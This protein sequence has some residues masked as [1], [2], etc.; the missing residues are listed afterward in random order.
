MPLAF[1][2]NNADFSNMADL[3]A[4]GERLY[5]DFVL[6]KAFVQVDENGTEAAAATAVGVAGGGIMGYAPPPVLFTAD[7][8]FQFYIRDNQTGTILFM[9]RV[10]D[11]TQQENDVTPIAQTVAAAS[12]PAIG[13]VVI[14]HAQLGAQTRG[15]IT[16]NVADAT[17]VQSSSI[18][19]DGNPVK[20]VYGP[21]GS[22][23]GGNY[24]ALCGTL[25]AGTNTC[26]I[27]A[28]AKNG[29]TSQYSE[30]FTLAGP[31]IGEI[32]VSH[33]MVRPQPFGEITWNATA[34]AGVQSA[35]ISIDGRV[36]AHLYGP[37]HAA[38]GA[39]YTAL[40]GALPAGTHDYIITATDGDGTT[41]LYA[42]KFTLAGPAIGEVAV[43]PT[44]EMITWNAAD[45]GATSSA[46]AIDGKPVPR[47]YG[48]FHAIAGVNYV[49][50][51][52]ALSAGTHTYV[53]TVTDADGVESQDTGTFTLAGSSTSE[54][55]RLA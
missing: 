43:S 38:S 53:I 26:V 9:G 35:S 33:T 10:T 11:P 15:L 47:L 46:I 55:G 34:A 24:A 19:I 37:L 28:T 31:A 17:G 4:S 5:I 20:S 14:S 40:F 22:A 13:E 18:M 49:A 48:P 29:N 2:A 50:L 36:P 8:P 3:S 30:T 54:G 45:V 1:D 44:Q 51:Y 16:W 25:P 27:S 32:A 7:H 39:N 21:I 12:G 23:S 41:S 52:G 42:G 6:H